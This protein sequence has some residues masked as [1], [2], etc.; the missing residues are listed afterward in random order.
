MGDGADR[1]LLAGRPNRVA[2]GMGGAS[3]Q[4]AMTK[5]RGTAT[6]AARR[7]DTE[8]RKICPGRPLSDHLWPPN[9]L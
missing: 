7:L 3:S 4:Q 9:A 1:G 6:H 5:F 8:P 2:P